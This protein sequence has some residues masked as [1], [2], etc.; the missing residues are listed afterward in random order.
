MHRRSSPSALRSVVRT[1]WR[2][3]AAVA[4]VVAAP[5]C[6]SIHS[7]DI[8]TDA[9]SADITV[10]P[11]KDGSAADV[12]VTLSAGALTFVDLTG[13]DALVARSGER[14]V[15]L[16]KNQA[17]GALAY[18]GT[19][20]GVG[21]SGD[22]VTVAFERT[23]FASAPA[24]TVTLPAAVSITA[25][26][27]AESFSRAENDVVVTIADDGSTDPVT[28]SWSG[29]CVVGGS[30][31]V[32]AGQTTAT[33]ARGTIQKAEPSPS[34]ADA[35]PIADTC[36]LHLSV[37][38]SVDGILDDAFSGGHITALTDD[39]RDVTTTP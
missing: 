18:E 10:H 5:A 17:L 22:E 27:A 26:A 39:G 28:L 2:A 9:I 38:R 20:D 35:A 31:D 13:G 15:Q 14:E 33:I 37:V 34:D 19:L 25:P 6:S 30:L 23:A 16:G 24:S 32:P 11:R 7:E 3:V 29:D 21:A 36:T 1:V 12:S 8:D 4:A